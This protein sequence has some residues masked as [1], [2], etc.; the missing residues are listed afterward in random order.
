MLLMKCPATNTFVPTGVAM[1]AASYQLSK[2][3]DNSSDCSACG[4]HHVWGETE[5]ALDN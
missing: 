2:L 5:T 1:D 4:R 3:S